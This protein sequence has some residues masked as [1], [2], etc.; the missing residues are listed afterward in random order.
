MAILSKAEI[1]KLIANGDLAFTPKLDSFQLRIHAVD[2][3]IGFT[4]MISKSWKMTENGREAIT[5]SMLT[6]GKKENFEVINLK[7]GQFFEILPREF[8]IATTMEKIKMPSN[9][10]AILYPRSSQ[11]RRGLSINLTGI[12]DAGYEGQLMI[13]IENKNM[14]PLRIYPGERFCQ[15]TFE[16][17]KGEVEKQPSRYHGKDVTIGAL[18]EKSQEEVDLIMQGKIKEL[19]KVFAAE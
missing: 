15:L 13:P 2:L 19:K 1:Q 18:P 16:E 5:K 17:I 6:N 11:N 3:R 4:F 9:L 8:I 10:M 7:E 14:E 12:I